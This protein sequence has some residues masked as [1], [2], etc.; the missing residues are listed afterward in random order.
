M[1]LIS[2][3]VRPVAPASPIAF[4]TASSLNGSMIAWTIFMKSPRRTR[5]WR[6]STRLPASA[7]AGP[8]AQRRG[9]ALEWCSGRPTCL[10][11]NRFES[12]KFAGFAAAGVNLPAR[13]IA[14]CQGGADRPTRHGDPAASND[15]EDGDAA[16]LR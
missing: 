5:R 6:E 4:F 2:L 7:K 13:G 14:L 11:G 10:S 1:P 16:T 12:D 15:A 3:M 8:A 9:A